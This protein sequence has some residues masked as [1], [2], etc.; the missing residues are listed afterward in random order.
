LKTRVPSINTHVVPVSIPSY[1]KDS[2]KPKIPVVTILTRNQGDAAKIAKSFYLQYPIYKWITF[3]ELR[4]L[5]RKQFASELAKSCLAVWVDE[6]S[7]LG[8]FPLEA[9]ESN[10]AV[11][12]KIPNMVPE[13]METKDEAGNAVI[14]NNGVWTNTTL[15]IPELIATYLKVWLEDSVPTDLVE[16]IIESKGSY[17]SEKQVEAATKV[18]NALQQ[19]RISEMKISLERL[20]DAQ[21]EL[22]TTNV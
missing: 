12:G 9:I 8:T 11:I 13:W 6:Q 20:E 4:G 3:K 2:D 16:S 15:N 22:Q 18:Y 7:S 1:F 5:P 21:K 17:T 14:K 10:T 19:N